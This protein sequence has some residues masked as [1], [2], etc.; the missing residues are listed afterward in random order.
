MGLPPQPCMDRHPP[1]DCNLWSGTYLGPWIGVS[2]S[3]CSV[4]SSVHYASSSPGQ[5]KAIAFHNP[6]PPC[7]CPG[8]HWKWRA[9]GDASVPCQGNWLRVTLDL[10][11][12]LGGRGWPAPGCQW[13]KSRWLSIHPRRVG[14]GG[15]GRR[16]RHVSWNSKPPEHAPLSIRLY[17]QSTDSDIRLI[18]NFRCWL[19]SSKPQA[20]GPWSWP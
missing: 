1:K 14:W 3:P 4:T 17:L 5:G 2:E 18:K 16:G 20:W 7:L 12:G 19:Q 13:G 8:P 6:W 9:A 11:W 10:R 15:E